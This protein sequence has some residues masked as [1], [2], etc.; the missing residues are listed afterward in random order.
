M[1][2]APRAFHEQA[3]YISSNINGIPYAMT[4]APAIRHQRVSQ[5]IAAVLAG[6]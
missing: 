2:T 6:C 3:G 4:P 1:Q 5:K